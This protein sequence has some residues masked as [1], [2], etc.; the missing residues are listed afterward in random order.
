MRH[1]R[2]EQKTPHSIKEAVHDIATDLHRLGF[3]DKRKMGKFDALCLE[4]QNWPDAPNRPD[5][6]SARFDPD[7]S[8]RNHTI[9]RFSTG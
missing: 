5:F 7:L 1:M 2:K 9:Y 3:I 4:P 6:P 8:Y